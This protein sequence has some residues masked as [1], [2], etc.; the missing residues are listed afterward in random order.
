[1]TE[2]VVSG[3]VVEDAPAEGSSPGHFLV[4]LVDAERLLHYAAEIGVV[5]DPATRDAVL[6]ARAT[7]AGGWSKPVAAGLLEALTTLSGLLKPVTASSL[8]A[9]HNT[10][11][12]MRSY[13]LW[14][15][16]LA[17]F[18]LPVSV[19]TFVS[20][21]ISTAL[22]DDIT[23]ANAL[24]VKLR[25]ELGPGPAG[26]AQ[27]GAAAAP[28]ATPEV[29]SDLQDYASTVRLINRRAIRLSWFV[30]PWQRR[31]AEDL[32][33]PDQRRSAFELPVNIP[34]PVAARDRLTYTYQDVRYYAQMLLTDSF[35]VYG[36]ITTCIL[37]VLYALLG[38]CAYL[39]R[40]FEDQM[41]RRTFTPSAANF[42]RFLIAGIGGAV[43]GLFN[44]LDVNQQAS[45]PPL[46]MAFLVGYAV[47]VFFAFL[48]GLL[49]AFTRTPAVGGAAK[50]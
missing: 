4:A 40:D 30:W 5:V 19:A 12:T 33:M 10:R 28:V 34:D 48:E 42:A 23:H 2:T 22:K 16:L 35:V 38:T 29:I 39:I 50:A 41:S 47:D 44:N 49:R 18:I 9:F 17:G 27:G 21:A 11:P 36:A 25:M 45:V 20:S 31:P 6:T 13:I 43:I 7:L 26:G 46:A 15:C 8:R 24:A 32:G 1:M 14:A 3:V 37:P